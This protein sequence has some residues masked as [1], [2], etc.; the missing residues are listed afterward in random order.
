MSTLYGASH[1][2]LVCQID[3][4]WQDLQT[5]KDLDPE[6]LNKFKQRYNV[7]FRELEATIQPKE[8]LDFM[9]LP[10]AKIEQLEALLLLL[11]YTTLVKKIDVP[12]A[13]QSSGFSLAKL[14]KFVEFS[15]YQS[16][17]LHKIPQR[18][19]PE[20]RVYEL[21]AAQYNAAANHAALAGLL[22]DLRTRHS[23]DVREL[24]GEIPGS[25]LLEILNIARKLVFRGM[26]LYDLRVENF[27]SKNWVPEQST[28]KGA[29]L[30]VTNTWRLGLVHASTDKLIIDSSKIVSAQERSQFTTNDAI[31]KV[32]SAVLGRDNNF[33]IKN[34]V[35]TSV[36][37][38]LAIYSEDLF[39]KPLDWE[40]SR[41]YAAVF[42]LLIQYATA[43]VDYFKTTYEIDL[44]KPTWSQWA[45]T[46]DIAF[47]SKAIELYQRAT[48]AKT[49]IPQTIKATN[50]Q[51]M[52][53]INTFTESPTEEIKEE[54]APQ[55]TILTNF[56]NIRLSAYA[57]LFS[58]H[59]LKPFLVKLH[60]FVRG[61]AV[62]PPDQEFAAM[63][64]PFFALTPRLDEDGLKQQPKLRV[65]ESTDFPKS[66]QMMAPTSSLLIRHW[67]AKSAFEAVEFMSTTGVGI[68]DG[69]T[70]LFG[71]AKKMQE[72]GSSYCF[73]QLIKKSQ[74]QLTVAPPLEPE[75]LEVLMLDA[76]GRHH[77]VGSRAELQNEFDMARQAFVDYGTWASLNPP[78]TEYFQARP[79]ELLRVRGLDLESIPELH[80][81]VLRGVRVMMPVEAATVNLTPNPSLVSGFS[82][83]LRIAQQALNPYLV[84]KLKESSEFQQ[85]WQSLVDLYVSGNSTREAF[86]RLCA[87]ES[88]ARDLSFD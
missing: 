5:T 51:V 38:A 18:L 4:L 37:D 58:P 45:Q 3:S 88:V 52:R 65:F 43:L 54:E 64:M 87:P 16:T 74:Q 59:L 71:F 9:Q 84:S 60:Q 83:Y 29:L 48:G 72:F 47:L 44:Q 82:D 11:E 24:S 34:L 61:D 33:D 36:R 23:A 17:Q 28:D 19:V 14:A 80:S 2:Q 7:I 6:L 63:F 75:T 10:R 73:S 50:E 22:A 66:R 69:N 1:S 81:S 27:R 40:T 31:R 76:L 70:R 68:P 67:A 32:T 79:C 30:L 15:R 53:A 49:N 41:F 20:N 25:S 85:L 46:H 21:R 12:T 62:G 39:T 35:R 78:T 77:N 56:D 26:S 42:A 8:L 13:E 57:F 86:M 55:D